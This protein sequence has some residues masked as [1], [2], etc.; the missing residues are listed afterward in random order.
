MLGNTVIKI[1]A[2]LLLC[3]GLSANAQRQE[4]PAARPLGRVDFPPYEERTL[5]NGLRV[6]AIEHYEQPVISIQL[7][8]AAGSAH[9]PTQLPGLA[10]F[11]SNLLMSGTG[12]R[13][14]QEIA[15]V[16]DY[17]GK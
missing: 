8:V 17:C 16:I 13:S 3:T 5:E 1:L 7:I 10:T 6:F 2:A 11:T 4:P 14:A 15:R 12:T 9:D